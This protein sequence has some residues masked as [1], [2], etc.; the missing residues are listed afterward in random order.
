MEASSHRDGDASQ[1]GYTYHEAS[2]EAAF[3]RSMPRRSC[4]TNFGYGEWSTTPPHPRN[5]FTMPPAFQRSTV[6]AADV[7]KLTRTTFAATREDDATFV[8]SRVS[9]ASIRIATRSIRKEDNQEEIQRLQLE[10]QQLEASMRKRIIRMQN[11]MLLL[12]KKEYNL[13]NS[14]SEK[15][16]KLEDEEEATQPFGT[17]SARRVDKYLQMR[18]YLP[19]I[20]PDKRVQRFLPTP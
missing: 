14:I 2:G 19:A 13:E 18:T 15:Q 3:A 9:Q 10:S 12:N 17:D 11:Q 4:R 16:Q 6:I 5:Q 8:S 20:L 1:G 7:R